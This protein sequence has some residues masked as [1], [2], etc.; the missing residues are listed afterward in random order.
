MRTLLAAAVA[1][2]GCYREPAPTTVSQPLVAAP[3]RTFVATAS[4][5]VGFLPIDSEVVAVVDMRT[6]RASAVWK[7]FEPMLMAKAGPTLDSIRTGC[8]FDPFEQIRRISFGFKNLSADTKPTGVMVV[9]GIERDATMRCVQRAHA[10][11]PAGSVVDMGG[12]GRP[13]TVAIAPTN[14][15]FPTVFAF[16]DPTTLV[17]VVDHNASLAALDEVLRRGSPL[18]SSPVF[19]E[20]MN[21]V[22]LTDPL[23]FVM[24]GSAKAFDKLGGLGFKPTAILGSVN[25]ANGLALDARIRLDTPDLAKSMSAMAQ[26]QLT[27]L[28]AMVEEIVVAAEDADLVVRVRMTQPQL[29]S[30]LGLFGG[31]TGP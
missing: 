16:I 4:D 23:W 3:T 24:N 10:T 26:N 21:H 19:V 12:N 11:N 30:M 6:L 15:E 2:A 27:M 31:F 25:L 9:K 5:P 7:R 29:D 8:G 14:G 18:R 1:L 17:V 28:Q 13:A 20:L 22:Q